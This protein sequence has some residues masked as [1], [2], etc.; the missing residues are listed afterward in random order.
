M[1]HCALILPSKTV[2]TVTRESVAVCTSVPSFLWN[3]AADNIMLVMALC[4]EKRYTIKLIW[5]IPFPHFPFPDSV[6]NNVSS[7]RSVHV[8]QYTYF[9]KIFTLTFPQANQISQTS[10]IWGSPD[11]L[12]YNSH[13]PWPLVMLRLIGNS[14][15]HR[16]STRLENAEIIKWFLNTGYS[17]LFFADTHIF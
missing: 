16:K 11:E 6:Q 14:L 4:F 17:H 5:R 7:N 15:K 9:T 8:S 12:D 3:S 1:Q 2:L 13:H 10:P